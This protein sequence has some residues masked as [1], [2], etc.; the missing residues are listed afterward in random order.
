MT[1]AAYGGAAGAAAPCAAQFCCAHLR[2]QNISYVRVGSLSRRLFAKAAF[3][4]NVKLCGE[5]LQYGFIRV[6]VFV[7]FNR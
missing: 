1:L 3:G 7:E 6:A 4:E 5:P 2:A